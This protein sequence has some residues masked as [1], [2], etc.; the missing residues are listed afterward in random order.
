MAGLM[1]ADAEQTPETQSTWEEAPIVDAPDAEDALIVDVD[2][3]G[4]GLARAHPVVARRAAERADDGI[5]PQ[6]LA[7]LA[8]GVAVADAVE[9]R[10]RGVR[11]C[12]AVR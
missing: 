2:E 10:H 1:S 11:R 8:H 6:F 12:G 4:A 5:R 9:G 7:R 3:F